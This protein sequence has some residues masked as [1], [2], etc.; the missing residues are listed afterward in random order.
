MACW[1][2]EGPCTWSKVKTCFFAAAPEAAAAVVD[3]PAFA[4]P[5]DVAS[6]LTDVDEDA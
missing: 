3:G 4:E 1:F 5:P 6:T 2:V